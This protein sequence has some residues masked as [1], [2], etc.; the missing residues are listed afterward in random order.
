MKGGPTPREQAVE[1]LRAWLPPE[2]KERIRRAI[3]TGEFGSGYWLEAH[4]HGSGR[5]ARNALREAGL[6]EAAL[7]VGNLDDIYLDLL[8][9]TGPCG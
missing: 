1:V 8:A 9:E 7:G 2:S 6:D 5:D 4:H 3:L